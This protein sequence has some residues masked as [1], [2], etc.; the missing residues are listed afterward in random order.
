MAGQVQKLSD[1]AARY[2]G[3]AHQHPHKRREIFRRAA[4]TF[5]G[6]AGNPANE[7]IAKRL[8]MFAQEFAQ[9]AERPATIGDFTDLLKETAQA[10]TE[11]A[12]QNSDIDL[13]A[14]RREI[15]E[16]RTG[17]LNRISIAPRSVTEDTAFGRVLKVKWQPNEADSRNG[18]VQQDTASQWQGDKAEAQAI[19]VQAG[20]VAAA[21]S[22]PTAGSRPYG[23]ISF[24]SDGTIVT[25]PFDIGRGVRFT[26]ACNF[27]TVLIGAEEPAASET[28]VPMSIGVSLGMFAAPTLAPVFRTV[29]VDNLGIGQSSG[30]LP[31]PA[32]GVQLYT[33]LCSRG[34]GQ[35]ALIFFDASKSLVVGEFN[36]N[37]GVPI[38]PIPIPNDA[39]FFQV[40]NYSGGQ[41]NIRLPFQLSL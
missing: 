36:L 9:A 4:N 21:E 26:V 41:A 23:Q 18:I 40:T 19:T 13:V 31:I 10:Y 11:I 6:L 35:L 25:V 5:L 28:A 34:V 20:V 12:D 27:V 37:S 30:V 3:A 22:T 14:R 2:I 16:Q 7:A 39:V 29:Y 33:P 24:G 15:H 1:M 38:V 8:N 17:L 32:A